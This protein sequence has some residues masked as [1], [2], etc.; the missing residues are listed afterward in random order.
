MFTDSFV[1]WKQ[2]E[3]ETLHLISGFI[4]LKGHDMFEEADRI[5]LD[6]I[7]IPFSDISHE[8]Y[9]DLG[10]TYLTQ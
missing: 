6:V 3:L 2:L 8:T 7:Y 10:G 4:G 9:M 1:A 5:S